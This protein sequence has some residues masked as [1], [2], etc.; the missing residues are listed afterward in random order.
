MVF[1]VAVLIAGLTLAFAAFRYRGK[2]A[3][4]EPTSDSVA[5]PSLPPMPALAPK[6][7]PE[8]PNIPRAAPETNQPE[9]EA[10]ALPSITAE[11][12]AHGT[13]KPPTT[14]SQ[15]QVVPSSPNEA[16]SQTLR[17]ATTSPRSSTKHGSPAA[18]YSVDWDAIAKR[19]ATRAE[20]GESSG[21]PSPVPAATQTIQ[22]FGSQRLATQ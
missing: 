19:A 22:S 11:S 6:D 14:V 10:P 21:E 2:I 16:R 7:P 17:S 20:D 5:R 4:S 18:L 12:Q 15:P 13:E 1:R 9:L 3:P 8:R